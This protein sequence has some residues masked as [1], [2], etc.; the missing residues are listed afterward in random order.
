MQIDTTNHLTRIEIDRSENFSRRKRKENNGES[1]IFCWEIE[2]RKFRLHPIPI[3]SHWGITDIY[4]F[5]FIDAV[6]SID[7]T[8]IAFYFL[9]STSSIANDLHEGNSIDS[10]L[11]SFIITNEIGERQILFSIQI[12]LHW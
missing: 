12:M 11:I 2:S 3:Q 7:N 5:F 9:N 1:N 10:Y 6:W 4:I 8:D